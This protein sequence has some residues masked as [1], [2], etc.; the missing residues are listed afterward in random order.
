MDLLNQFVK[1][2]VRITH[3]HSNIKVRNSLS[4]QEVI[5][6]EDSK[7]IFFLQ[8]DQD[9]ILVMGLTHTQKASS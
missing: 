6:T 5:L 9:I 2:Q 1:L 4:F 7:L 8:G 3:H